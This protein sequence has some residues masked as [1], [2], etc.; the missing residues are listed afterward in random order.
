MNIDRIIVIGGSAGSFPVSNILL[1]QIPKNFPIPIVFCM[2]RLK[3][4]R[5]GFVEALNLKTNIP[6]IEPQDK[7]K[8][9][10]NSIYL[11]PAN[12]HLLVDY[13]YTFAY[14]VAESVRYS[15]PSIDVLFISTALVFGDKTIGI[16]LS[17]ANTDG[18]E[19][20]QAIHQQGGITIVQDPATCT[21]QTMTQ[22]AIENVPIQ[23][24]LPPEKI[25]PTLISL[26][27]KHS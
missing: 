16:L 3:N 22:S 13:D 9:K 5:H 12:Y 21:V 7:D 1:T 26:I 23:Y 11:A 24:V 2:H 25:I 15:R 10:P 4:I 14:S 17:G 8:I 6:V 27:Q 20:M 19:G 18:T